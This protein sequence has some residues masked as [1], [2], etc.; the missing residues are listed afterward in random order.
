MQSLAIHRVLHTHSSELNQTPLLSWMNSVP[1]TIFKYQGLQME[2][3][4]E[5][6]PNTTFRLRLVHSSVSLQ[7]EG[8]ALL[9]YAYFYFHLTAEVYTTL[10]VSIQTIRQYAPKGICL[11]IDINL[12][13]QVQTHP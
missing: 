9:I 8:K 2:A 1:I 5:H 12:A 13:T 10:P 6:K 3:R 7:T 4:L 11:F